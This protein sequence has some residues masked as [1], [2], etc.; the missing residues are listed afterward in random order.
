MLIEFEFVLKKLSLES[1]ISDI[2]SSS[3]KHDNSMEMFK[4]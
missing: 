2:W 1:A 3:H 4:T